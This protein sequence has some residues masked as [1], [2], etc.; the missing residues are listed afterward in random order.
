MKTSLFINMTT[1]RVS[2]VA[3]PFSDSSYKIGIVTVAEVGIM[4]DS[5]LSDDLRCMLFGCLV[6]EV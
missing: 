3:R 6:D 4:F 1:I 2:E 5:A